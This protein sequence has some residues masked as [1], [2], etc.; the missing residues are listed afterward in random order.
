M[1]SS[2]KPYSFVM[3]DGDSFA[4]VHRSERA[5]I[6]WAREVFERIKERNYKDLDR[7]AA[8]LFRHSVA[9][10]NRPIELKPIYQIGDTAHCQ[11]IID[12][13]N[14]VYQRVVETGEEKFVSELP[15]N[16]FK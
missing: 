9:P 14:K 7:F 8:V 10:Y 11:A 15:H 12:G 6:L 2:L 3:L 1:D 4:A 13:Q 5:G 16:D